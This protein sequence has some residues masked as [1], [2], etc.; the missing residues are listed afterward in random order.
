MV[1]NHTQGHDFNQTNSSDAPMASSNNKQQEHGL[2]VAAEVGLFVALAS[3]VL[4]HIFIYFNLFNL[5][6]S[7]TKTVIEKE[8]SLGNYM[9]ALM[10]LL[11]PFLKLIIQRVSMSN[12]IPLIQLFSFL[13]IIWAV[14]VLL[15]LGPKFSRIHSVMFFIW[16]ILLMLQGSGTLTVGIYLIILGLLFIWPSRKNAKTKSDGKAA[17]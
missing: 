5:C 15:L 16:S 13:V 10:N 6:F 3:M 8:T 7:D 9:L 11:C 2:K 14:A 17:A 1:Q 4:V 12:V